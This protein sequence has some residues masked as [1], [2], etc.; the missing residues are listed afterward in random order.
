MAET[1][2]ESTKREITAGKFDLLIRN[3]V[4]DQFY[5]L[6]KMLMCF[7]TKNSMRKQMDPSNLSIKHEAIAVSFV[8][9]TTENTEATLT[10]SIFILIK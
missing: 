1:L 10:F 2:L 8:S 7:N 3:N 6:N 4:Y 5:I 9:I